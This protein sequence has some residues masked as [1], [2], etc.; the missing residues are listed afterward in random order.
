MMHMHLS[1]F[2]ATIYGRRLWCQTGR[3]D[4]ATPVSSCSQTTLGVQIG[5][6]GGGLQAGIGTF[7]WQAGPDSREETLE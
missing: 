5:R 7:R 3:S 4:T 6:P 1:Y 2:I